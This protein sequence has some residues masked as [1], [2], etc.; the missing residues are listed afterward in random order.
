M[1][2]TKGTPNCCGLTGWIDG[3]RKSFILGQVTSTL[4][5]PQASSAI[6]IQSQKG[7]RSTGLWLKKTKKVYLDG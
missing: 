2:G 5:N 3:W 4:P 1:P 6:S 7:F